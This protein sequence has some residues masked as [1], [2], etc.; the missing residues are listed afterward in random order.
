MRGSDNQ[1][2]V[3]SHDSQL[4]ALRPAPPSACAGGG[5]T[6]VDFHPCHPLTPLHF[7]AR[8]VA[9]CRPAVPR[10]WAWW[11]GVALA[12]GLAR[13][14][15]HAADSSSIARHLCAPPRPSAIKQVGLGILLPTTSRF[16][17]AD[18]MAAVLK[19]LSHADSMIFTG[20][21]SSSYRLEHNPC[22]K[23]H[24]LRRMCCK[25][26]RRGQSPPCRDS[27]GGESL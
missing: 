12:R 14:R 11:G 5:G 9:V 19:E 24:I 3:G 18:C 7:W 1:A 27:V 16:L 26:P 17:R 20:D 22:E 2:I 10:G 25:W 15:R 6:R 13:G 21:F 4:S 23:K 8:G